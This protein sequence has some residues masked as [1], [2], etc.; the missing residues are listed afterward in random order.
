MYYIISLQHTHRTDKYITLWRPD[1]KGYCYS[2]ES[3]G[4]YETPK[5]NYHDSPSN[6]P[7]KVEDA[8][9]LFLLLPYEGEQKFMIP[10]IKLV[11][12]KLGFKM[13]KNGLSKIKPVINEN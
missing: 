12:D 10:N 11:W 8:E 9:N 2:K 1:N 3:A 6:V 7:I 13:T 4:I 5:E